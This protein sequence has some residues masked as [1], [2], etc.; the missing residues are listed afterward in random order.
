MDKLR[1]WFEWMTNKDAKLEKINIK[2][3]RLSKS[4]AFNVLYSLQ[5]FLGIVSDEVEMCKE[6]KD[7]IDMAIGEGDVANEEYKQF[8]IARKPR[9]HEEGIYCEDCLRNRFGFK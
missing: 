6:C 9:P 1:E 2:S 4:K 7:L 8:G 5:E 3:P